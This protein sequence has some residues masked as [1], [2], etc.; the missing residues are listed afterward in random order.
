MFAKKPIDFYINN[1]PVTLDV[2]EDV[3]D[4]HIK[5]WIHGGSHGLFPYDKIPQ[6]R[7]VSHVNVM[8]CNSDT[9]ETI[10]AFWVS[11]ASRYTWCI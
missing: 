2:A 8:T 10:C 3:P 1:V 9:F 6:L 7:Y 4:G 11:H 5:L